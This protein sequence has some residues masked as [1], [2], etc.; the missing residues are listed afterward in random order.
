LLGTFV[1]RISGL[2]DRRFLIGSWFPSLS[3]GVL[4]ANI[5]IFAR[6]WA[7]VS[8]MWAGLGAGPQIWVSISGSSKLTGM[9]FPADYLACSPGGCGA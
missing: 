2:F 9:G 1:N 6:G 8:R 4:L 7:R 3:G 5:L